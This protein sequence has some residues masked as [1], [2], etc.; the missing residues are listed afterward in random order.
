MAPEPGRSFSAHFHGA[1]P[2]PCC[3]ATV[4]CGGNIEKWEFVGVLYWDNGK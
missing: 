3:S 2:A 4:A 1:P